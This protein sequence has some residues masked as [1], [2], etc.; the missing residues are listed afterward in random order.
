[1]KAKSVR[2]QFYGLR[3]PDLEPIYL[4]R[5]GV[6]FQIAGVILQGK[7]QRE[8]I[9]M[10]PG[11]KLQDPFGHTIEYPSLDDWFS[12]LKYTDNPQHFEL[13]SSGKVVK[14]IHRKS[15][16]AIGQEV[17]WKVYRRAGFKC[18]YDYAERALTVDHKIPVELGGTDEDSNLAACCKSCNQTKANMSWED[19]LAY[20]GANPE[21]YVGYKD[22]V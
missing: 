5:L 6:E 13:D 16:R 17:Q 7:R 19:W 15:Q 21:R 18:E 8:I 4:D 3:Y 20:M 9:L 2:K 22:F 12:I 10:L 14:A 1:M 11:Y